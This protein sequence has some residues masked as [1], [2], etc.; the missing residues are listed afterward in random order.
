MTSDLYR[1]S[2][3]KRAPQRDAAY[4]DTRWYEGQLVFAGPDAAIKVIGTNVNGY[5]SGVASHPEGQL[6]ALIAD[7]EASILKGAGAL[8]LA[9][10][11]AVVLSGK[12]H[13]VDPDQEPRFEAYLVHLVAADGNVV[14][15]RYASEIFDWDKE[16]YNNGSGFFAGG[17]QGLDEDAANLQGH[18]ELKLEP[19]KISAACGMHA[20]EGVVW[21]PVDDQRLPIVYSNVNGPDAPARSVDAG[22]NEDP[23]VSYKQLGDG[24][25]LGELRA[26]SQALKESPGIFR[27]KAVDRPTHRPVEMT[28]GEAFASTD[29]LGYWCQIHDGVNE[30][31]TA[32]ELMHDADYLEEVLTRVDAQT[33]QWTCR[34][35]YT[36]E[37]KPL[38]R[39]MP[40]YRRR[41]LAVGSLPAISRDP[42]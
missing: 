18:A 12:W 17:G 41:I 34:S 19:G 1:I 11:A 35:L 3:Y 21:F 40:K 5:I 23:A 13:H 16:G 9:D 38:G 15:Q 10:T 6:A 27:G 20:L 7:Y 2:R 28:L 30:P 8:R 25:L 33:D 31:F 4:P 29:A 14:T 36:S 22:S 37:W 39:A 42:L 26:R 24:T 32:F